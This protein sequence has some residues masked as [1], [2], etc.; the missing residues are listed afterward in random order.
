V[1]YKTIKAWGKDRP[2]IFIGEW[3]GGCTAND[4]FF[5]HF[6]PYDDIPDF[7]YK[8]W[9]GMYDNIYVGKYSRKRIKRGY[10]D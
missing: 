10:D 8:S 3:H 7:G 9:P 4:K 1:A 6:E 2:I 5:E